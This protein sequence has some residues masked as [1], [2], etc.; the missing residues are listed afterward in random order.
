M[1]LLKES[2]AW[3]L[4]ARSQMY[5]G[6]FQTSVNVGFRNQGAPR[7]FLGFAVLSAQQPFGGSSGHNAAAK[8]NA[9]FQL[10]I[11]RRAYTL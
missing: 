7:G 6:M 2:E 10:K 8:A 11:G 1:K 9:A 3:E 4:I 5:L